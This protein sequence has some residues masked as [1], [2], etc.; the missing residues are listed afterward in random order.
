VSQPQISEYNLHKLFIPSARLQQI[1]FAIIL[2]EDDAFYRSVAHRSRLHKYSVIR[3]RDPVKLADNLPELRPE[4][5]IIRGL[6]FP[7]HWEVLASQLLCSKTLKTVRIVL[8]LAESMGIPAA[9]PN[10]SILYE[11]TGRGTGTAL[12][13]EA[14]KAL[15]ALLS[16]GR[17][18]R[19]SREDSASAPVPASVPASGRSLS[20]LI[21]AAGKSSSVKADNL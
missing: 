14:S 20:R 3:Y 8:F 15:S 21:S 19:L 17:I 5:I 16:P 4:L 13:E 7:L 1:M 6:D 18:S 9:W 2:S 11:P 10:V 12:S